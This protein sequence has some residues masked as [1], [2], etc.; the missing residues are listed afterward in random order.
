MRVVGEP[1]IEHSKPVARGTVG[2]YGAYSPRTR[3]GN[4]QDC[5]STVPFGPIEASIASS[6]LLPPARCPARLRTTSHVPLWRRYAVMFPPRWL[7]TRA[8]AP[9]VPCSFVRRVVQLACQT[10]PPDPSSRLADSRRLTAGSP[11]PN[12]PKPGRPPFQH[13]LTAECCTLTATLDV[14]SFLVRVY[15][16]PAG[17]FRLVSDRAARHL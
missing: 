9:S 13:P 1:Q 16:V 4:R 15:A 2:P 7:P 5:P 8:V 3:E 12:E 6:P 10:K 14:T 11:L 17:V